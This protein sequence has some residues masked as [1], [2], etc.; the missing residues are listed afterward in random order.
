MIIS[1]KVTDKNNGEALVGV[2]VQITELNIGTVSDVNGNYILENIPKGEIII[3]FSYVGFKT[4]FKK[5]GS[6]SF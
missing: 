2:N 3:K 1:G 4:I 6:L 5:S